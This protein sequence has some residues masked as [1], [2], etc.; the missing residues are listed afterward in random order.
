MNATKYFKETI[1][2]YLNTRANNDELFARNY[3]KDNKNIDECIKY[4]L[5]KVKESG[6]NGFHD[7]EI[8]SMAVHYYDEDDIQTP[9][10]IN[11]NVVVNHTIE[12]TDEEKDEAKQ[13]AIMQLQEEYLR[14]M[15]E[16]KK[17][18]KSIKSKNLEEEESLIANLFE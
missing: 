16:P 10:D 13:K 11:C 7:D 3:Q 4:I 1:E 5:N 2:N 12:L 17:S 8:Y 15:K 14:K 6:C 9:K 18:M